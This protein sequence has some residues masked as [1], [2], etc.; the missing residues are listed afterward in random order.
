MQTSASA[1]AVVVVLVGATISVAAVAAAAA[2]LATRRKRWNSDRERMQREKLHHTVATTLVGPKPQWL[3][4][5]LPTI[6]DD[7]ETVDATDNSSNK[8]KSP[9]IQVLTTLYESSSNSSIAG[10]QANDPSITAVIIHGFGC[11]S[12]EWGPFI[13]LLKSQSDMN[14]FTYDR[15]LLVQ[16]EGQELFIKPRDAVTLANELHALLQ[17]RCQEEQ[18]K[19]KDNNLQPHGYL[20]IG[21][22]YGGLIAQHYAKLYPDDVHGMVLIDPAH[23]E[24]FQKFPRDFAF[25]FTTVVPILFKLYQRIAWTGLLVWL[26]HMSFFNFPP[27]FLLQPRANPV[28]RA[29]AQLYSQDGSVWK[30]VSAELQGCSTTFDR[31]NRGDDDL[32]RDQGSHNKQQR[33]T[34]PTSLVIA[35]NR[36]YSPTLFPKQVTRAFL[37][38]HAVCLQHAK[39]FIAHDSDHWVHMS[40]PEVV[41]EA[42]QYVVNELLKRNG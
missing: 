36:R 14:I 1:T 25:G 29:C 5:V 38:M 22:S 9:Q 4:V 16:D 23:E 3:P 41:L 34:I 33:A 21:H 2:A 15:V 39:V 11:T 37:D 32:R 31:M 42:V 13:E 6:V 28:R 24:Q 8:Q 10:P 20:L 17:N 7:N 27:L 30:L 40:E 19:D 26:D 35:G 12:L 18:R